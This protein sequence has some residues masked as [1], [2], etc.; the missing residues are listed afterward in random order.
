MG[1]VSGNLTN[2]VKYCFVHLKIV[3]VSDLSDIIGQPM[4]YIRPKI[5]PFID[6]NMV[7]RFEYE[8][9]TFFAWNEDADS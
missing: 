6:K 7:V 8:R 5:T 9:K 1:I 3:T 4:H 2:D